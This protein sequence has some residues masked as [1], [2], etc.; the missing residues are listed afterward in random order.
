[1]VRNVFVSYST[2]DT[3]SAEQVRVEGITGVRMNRLD[4][5]E[6]QLL[7]TASVLMVSAVLV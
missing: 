5:E 4:A 2:Q 1:M 7:T 3:A 6:R